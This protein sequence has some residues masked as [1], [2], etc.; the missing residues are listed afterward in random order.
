VKPLFSLSN[1]PASTAG[2]GAAVLFAV[3]GGFQ[4]CLA[5]GAPWGEAAFGGANVGVLS[6]TLRVSSAVAAVVYLGL[7][8][9]AGTPMLG[10]TLRRRVLYGVAP[11]M[12]VGAL[13]NL[14]SPSL[15]ERMIWTPVTVALAISL[16]RAARHSSLKPAPV[17]RPAVALP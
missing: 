14:A 8:L 17:T 7:S 16:W 6:D 3:V 13:V 11:V 15:P 2:R 9:V 1:P 5:A 12:V 4:I 10:A